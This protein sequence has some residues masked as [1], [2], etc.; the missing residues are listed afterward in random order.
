MKAFGQHILIAAIKSLD[1]GPGGH[2]GFLTVHDRREAIYIMFALLPRATQRQLGAERA[3]F[4]VND[5]R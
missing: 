2:E 1:G 3:D 4:W 5:G